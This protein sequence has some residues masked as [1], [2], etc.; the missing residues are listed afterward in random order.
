[1]G[2]KL[3]TMVYALVGIPLGLVVFQSIGERLNNFASFVIRNFKRFLKYDSVEA[4]ETN[5]I[6]V[7]TAITILTITGGAAAFSKYEGW[8]YFDSIYY[9]FVTLTTIGFGDMVALQQDNAL[10]DKPEYVAFVLIFILLGLSIVA[11]WLNLLILRLI[12]LNTE[13]ER[14]DEAAAVKALQGAVRLEG[15]IIT[16]NGSIL[17]GQIPREQGRG[18]MINLDDSKS[19]CSCSWPQHCFPCMPLAP[20]GRK[21]CKSGADFAYNGPR[22]A[23][24][25]GAFGRSYGAL[26]SA[27]YSVASLS[28]D[29][30]VFIE[31]RPEEHMQQGEYSELQ[32]VDC[33]TMQQQQQ[34]Q[35]QQRHG[36]RSSGGGGVV[37]SS[38]MD[39]PCRLYEARSSVGSPTPDRVLTRHPAAGFS[40]PGLA[41]RLRHFRRRLFGNPRPSHHQRQ[42]VC[43]ARSRKSSLAAVKQ[44]TIVQSNCAPVSA[45]SAAV[46]AAA[47][48]AV[49]SIDFVDIPL[50]DNTFLNWSLSALSEKRASL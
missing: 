31:Q 18:S 50:N 9:C 35:Q 14:R 25:M 43:M 38:G 3:F 23:P 7:V 37:Y 15:D 19:V 2:G 6:L 45:V 16:A 42:R 4:S 21:K 49:E 22:V 20:N 39:S 34:Q 46:S 11:A 5:L 40:L 10:T 30:D 28:C 33:G 13:D 26:S 36:M 32:N 17:S 48:G 29:N 8:S 24:A 41:R 1:M 12:T 44:R 27:T 47:T